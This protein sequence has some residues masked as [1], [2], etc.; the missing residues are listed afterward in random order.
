MRRG[1]CCLLKWKDVDLKN[2]FITVK[3]AK[4]GQTVDIPIFPLLREE[5]ERA[6]GITEHSEFCFPEAA[7]MYQTN[8]AVSPGGSS[9]CW[10][11]PWRGRELR[12][13]SSRWRRFHKRK[14][15]SEVWNTWRDSR[16]PTALQSNGRC[17]RHTW[18]ATAWMK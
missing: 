11:A 17:L 14:S 4:T 6:R 5:L 13:R 1:D 16:R 7:V 10:G 18:T 2:G 15:E 3:T 12:N 8:P 9:R